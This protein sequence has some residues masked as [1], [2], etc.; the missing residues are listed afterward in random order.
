MVTYLLQGKEGGGVEVGMGVQV[1]NVEVLV[2]SQHGTWK[3]VIVLCLKR[4][5]CVDV[6]V[7]LR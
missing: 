2:T 5:D 6:Y 3:V 7:V 1:N 4:L